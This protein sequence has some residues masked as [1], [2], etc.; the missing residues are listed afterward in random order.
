MCGNNIPDNSD[1]IIQT[2]LRL[3]PG[4]GLENQQARVTMLEPV[5][6]VR[7]APIGL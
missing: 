3:C 2:F 5:I 4:F 7:F 6:V 1:G